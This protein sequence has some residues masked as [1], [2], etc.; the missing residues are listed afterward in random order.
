MHA[1]IRTYSQPPTR[2]HTYVHT[3]LLVYAAM[4]IAPSRGL[5]RSSADDG[6]SYSINSG[7]DGSH[8]PD[9]SSSGGSSSGDG[10][11][12]SSGSADGSSAGSGSSSAWFDANADS[13][14]LA[15]VVYPMLIA[16]VL[17]LLRFAELAL[18]S[19]RECARRE[20][21]VELG[22]GMI[23]LLMWGGA[24][25]LVHFDNDEMDAAHGQRADWA[26]VLLWVGNIWWTVARTLSPIVIRREVP[27][28]QSVACPHHGYTYTRTN[29]FMFL[30]LGESVLQIVIAAGPP[31]SAAPS[32][33]SGWYFYTR[34][35]ATAGFVIALCIMHNFRSIVVEQ[36]EWRSHVNQ[37]VG[38]RAHE[39][40][41]I[42]SQIEEHTNNL[43]G[44]PVGDSRFKIQDSE[45]PTGATPET[46]D[47][48]PLG[49]RAGARQGV[50]T[51]PLGARAGALLG[52]K[53]SP[54]GARAGVRQG[55]KN[56]GAAAR[57]ADVSRVVRCSRATMI[58]TMNQRQA[59]AIKSQAASDK[60]IRA[61]IMI[62][63]IEL[64]LWQWNA[65]AVLLTGAALKSAVNQPLVWGGGQ[66]AQM[67]RYA[68]GAPIALSFAI[69]LCFRIGI[70]NRHK[71][72]L[73]QLCRFPAHTC[74]VICRVLLLGVSV[75]ACGPYIPSLQ[76]IVHE[77]RPVDQVL[78]QAGFCVLQLILQHAQ[79][80]VFP[81]S[82]AQKTP[83]AL[84]AEAFDNTRLKAMRYRNRR[85]LACIDPRSW[86][87]ASFSQEATN[88]VSPLSPRKLMRSPSVFRLSTRDS[89]EQADDESACQGAR[90]RTL[91]VSIWLLLRG[92]TLMTRACEAAAHAA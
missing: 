73:R 58:Q 25:F 66:Y 47:Q 45:P 89:S 13:E 15:Y 27:I 11:G 83:D 72:S 55:V 60:N 61:W 68:L 63:D 9:D 37:Q 35:T 2:M 65:I 84:L 18:F 3:Q 77:L 12:S 91:L 88:K 59:E 43:R 50:K 76:W 5:Y 69:Q 92:R 19:Q 36:L 48:S 14:A 67:Q 87:T 56:E 70:K 75:I 49:A 80:V 81:I 26:A 6:S 78:I 28:E 41:Q 21:A 8:G 46:R 51:S 22:I 34:I 31:S 29:E 38:K 20:N 90:G 54:F 57:W 16:L 40:A 52:V 62:S 17:W 4:A 7:S 71:Y 1:R 23:V 33:R 32:L 42:M 64:F 85:S 44:S 30:M 86:A 24:A 74:V 79:T 82:T 10:S 39:E 53:T